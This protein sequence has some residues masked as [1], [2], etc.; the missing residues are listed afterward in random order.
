LLQN[1]DSALARREILY[2]LACDRCCAATFLGEFER[3]RGSLK[4]QRP[5]ARSIRLTDSDREGWEISSFLAAALK[6]AASAAATKI[7]ICRKVIFIVKAYEFIASHY[8]T[9]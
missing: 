1:D 8:F 5:A 4:Q 2:Q 6:V 3:A 9:R 7:S